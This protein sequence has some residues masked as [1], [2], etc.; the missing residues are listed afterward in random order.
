MSMSIVYRT[1]DVAA[2]LTH[3]DRL[4]FPRC[5]LAH[6]P[7][8]FSSSHQESRHKENI[9][10]PAAALGWVRT[11]VGCYISQRHFTEKSPKDLPL[12]LGLCSTLWLLPGHYYPGNLVALLKSQPHGL[13]F[14]PQSQLTRLPLPGR[15]DCL[16]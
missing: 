10:I 12:H 15:Q 11:Q 7:C 3:E 5:Q 13:A 8:P 1:H 6:A 9:G 14:P 4:R 2:S 16:Q